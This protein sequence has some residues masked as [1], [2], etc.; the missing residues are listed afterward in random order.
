M[1]H[2]GAIYIVKTKHVNHSGIQ[3]EREKRKY[4][5]LTLTTTDINLMVS[6]AVELNTEQ[7]L[8]EACN[9]V[10]FAG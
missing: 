4:I 10:I 7:S 9:E 1:L 2:Y 3:E 5:K 8:E 6:I